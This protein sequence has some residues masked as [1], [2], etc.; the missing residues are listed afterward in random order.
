ML[1]QY[2]RDILAGAGV[3]EERSIE[4]NCAAGKRTLLLHAGELP[5]LRAILVVAEDLTRLTAGGKRDPLAVAEL[6]HG[7]KN[8]FQAMKYLARQTARHSD[9][10]ESFWNAFAGRLSVFSSA[11]EAWVEGGAPVNLQTAV[12]RAAPG[13]KFC[14]T[15][16][17]A[18]EIPP[19]EAL[20]L[21]LILHE[22][23]TNALKYGALSRA[24]G[25]AA[26]SWSVSG[27]GRRIHMLW[28][29]SGGP[30]TVPP[31]RKGFGTELI[32]LL[33]CSDLGG[34]V[35]LRFERGGLQCELD[36]PLPEGGRAIWV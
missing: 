1:A 7:I 17:L 31:R 29:E 19:K 5:C 33:A 12:E 27:D 20:S 25:N 32:E 23:Y 3:C 28:T 10:L 26:V 34:N 24:K 4:M 30:E 9:S 36:F 21:G 16:G 13:S 14:I 11:Q 35:E 22:L 8:A 6:G 18:L 2:I 15:A